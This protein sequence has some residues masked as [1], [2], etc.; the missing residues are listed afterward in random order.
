MGRLLGI[1]T[2]GTYTDAVLFDETMGVVA[3]AKALTTKHDLA[4]GVRGAVAEVLAGETEAVRLVSLSTTLATNAIVEGHGAP[5]CLLLL[6]YGEDA[7]ERSGLGQALG[8][9]P[10]V[11]IGGGHDP[12]GDEQRPLDLEAAREAILQQAP[13]VAAFAVAGYFGVRNPSHEL[14]VRDLVR[15][16]TGLPV[17]CAHELTSNLDAP[18]RALTAVLNARLIPQLQ[19]LILAVRGFLEEIGIEAPLMVVKGDGSLISDEV[20]LT[21]PVET[22]LSG[23]AA[24]V[25]G[26]RYLSQ[27][28]DVIVSDIGGTTT[29]IAVLRDGR[30]LLNRDG[31]TV[32]GWRTMVEAVAVHTCGLGGDSEV[33][34]A[35][36]RGL[37]VGPRR[38]VPLSLLACEHS[39]ILAPLREQAARPEAGEHDGRFALRLRP[40]GGALLTPSETRL[41]QAMAEG[42]AALED[43]LPSSAMA[44]PL[45]RLLD[46]GLVILG[47]FAPS[48]AAHLLG[49]QEGWSR[50]AAHLGAELMARQGAAR[51]RLPA[52]TAEELARATVERVIVQSGRAVVEAALA[53][54]GGLSAD[55][56]RRLGGIFVER[57]L[58]PAAAE[59]DPLV[60]FAVA[61]KRPLAAIG[62]PAA[63]Y[64]P[65][66]AERLDT[67]LVIPPHAAVTN[68]VGAVAGGVMQ[69]VRLLITAPE[70]GCYR[71]HSPEGPEDFTSLEAADRHAEAAA[72]RLAEAQAR[73]AGAATVELELRRAERAAAV[74]GGKDIF[75]DREITATAVG[76]PRLAG[77]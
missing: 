14:E 68:A 58:T 33:R 59:A 12:L 41:W 36:P 63:T 66:V 54:E 9:D 56:R 5:V 43:L 51:R 28:V 50:E 10:V 67:R 8:T 49:L 60:S 27:E 52:M 57:A 53:E 77:D 32:G 30:P 48:D 19:Q 39:Q 4:I 42:P 69:S 17:T 26:A 31:A 23:P 72:R 74:A 64:Y 6:G 11:F 21:C 2:G 71:V 25:V 3:S 34:L 35:E 44:R 76:R 73:A 7:L 75:V 38:V 62:A 1:D 70:E 47:A 45:G 65:A 24:S 37:V 20:A 13:K 29:D 46:R 18:R 22:I 61:L 40:L 55:D 16:L 15:E